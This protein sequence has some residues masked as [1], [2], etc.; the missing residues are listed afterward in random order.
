MSIDNEPMRTLQLLG[1]FVLARSE[2]IAE[3]AEH[4]DSRLA[5]S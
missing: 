5:T 4:G 3:R 1:A 2:E